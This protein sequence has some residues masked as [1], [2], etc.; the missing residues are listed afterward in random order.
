MRPLWHVL[1]GLLLAARPAASRR[2]AMET[3]T[4]LEGLGNLGFGLCRGGFGVGHPTEPPALL[5][6]AHRWWAQMGARA[7]GWEAPCTSAAGVGFS[8]RLGGF[9]VGDAAFCGLC[10]L[11]RCWLCPQGPRRAGS[12]VVCPGLVQQLLSS[13][14]F[15]FWPCTRVLTAA[16]LGAWGCCTG[17]A[18]RGCGAAALRAAGFW[19]PASPAATTEPSLQRCSDGVQGQQGLA[20]L[21]SAPGLEQNRIIIWGWLFQQPCG[22][23]V[24]EGLML[25]APAPFPSPARQDGLG[26]PAPAGVSPPKGGWHCVALDRD[27]PVPGSRWGSLVPVPEGRVQPSPVSAAGHRATSCRVL[28]AGAW[29]GRGVGGVSTVPGTQRVSAGL[30]SCSRA[31]CWSR[32]RNISCWTQATC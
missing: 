1:A 25:R 5:V 26:H 14:V 24:Q 27:T 10:M 20:A 31:P 6:R 15:P 23:G 2:G 9:W 4:G 7:G 17:P 28:P 16:A 30:Q 13:R 8:A 18:D 12:P 32:R 11:A 21:G 3:G 22:E 19:V 29:R